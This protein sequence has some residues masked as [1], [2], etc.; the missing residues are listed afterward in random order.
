MRAGW[1]EIV[2]RGEKGKRKMRGQD[3]RTGS[4]Q[5]PAEPVVG[6]LEVVGLEE[7]PLLQDTGA[8]LG[9]GVRSGDR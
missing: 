9:S 6:E 8:H 3:E 4:L 2:R 7:Q 5:P 1:G